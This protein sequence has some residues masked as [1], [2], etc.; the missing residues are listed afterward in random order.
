MFARLL[1]GTALAVL[2]YQMGRRAGRSDAAAGQHGHRA[3]RQHSHVRSRLPA[4]RR[5]PHEPHEE[6]PIEAPEPPDLQRR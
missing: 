4:E 3:V 1:A 6:M 5:P 2:A